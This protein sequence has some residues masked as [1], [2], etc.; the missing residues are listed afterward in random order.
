MEGIKRFGKGTQQHPRSHIYLLHLRFWHFSR[1]LDPRVLK[2]LADPELTAKLRA[3]GEGKVTAQELQ[4]YP[5]MKDL[6][7]VLNEIDE[8][9]SAKKESAEASKEA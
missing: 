3:W 2:A 5:K 4:E 9:Q 8:A 6:I 1:W 7:A